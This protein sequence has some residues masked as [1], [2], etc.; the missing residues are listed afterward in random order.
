MA[1]QGDHEDIWEGR[2]VKTIEAGKF[3]HESIIEK[4]VEM[5]EQ[6]RQVWTSRNLGFRGENWRRVGNWG[7]P[8]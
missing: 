8:K 6:I 4:T 2:I 7:L 5:V 3:H 1:S